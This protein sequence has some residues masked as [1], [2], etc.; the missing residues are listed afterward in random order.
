LAT[1]FLSYNF[2]SSPGLQHGE[3]DVI[4]HQHTGNKLN[5]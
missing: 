2:F 1:T 3:V 5:T 4:S